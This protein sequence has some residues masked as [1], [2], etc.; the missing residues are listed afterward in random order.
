M[1]TSDIQRLLLKDRRLQ[2]I[3]SHRAAF[4]VGS[5]YPLE[6]F[7]KFVA[8]FDGYCA[9]EAS[10]KVELDKLIAGRFLIFFLEQFEEQLAKTLD[11]FRKVES[12]A[13][14]KISYNLLY[15]FLEKNFDFTK[16]KRLITG[17]DLRDNLADSSLKMHIVLEN[18]PEKV[19]TALA[20]DGNSSAVLRS[21]ALQ[22]VSL[23]GFD[24]YLDGRSEIEIYA[25]LT[26]EQF[27]EADTQAFLKQVFP[28]PVLQPLKATDTF[29]IGL[30][31]ANTQPVLYYH[32]KN[33]KEFLDYFVINDTAQKVHSFYQHQTHLDL[34]LGVTQ[35]ELQN[36][37]IENIRLYYSMMEIKEKK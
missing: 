8:D 37:R 32:L 26:E 29:I 34:W 23:I 13:D 12:R 1:M 35:Q 24:F 9:I 10:C 33:K 11:F 20:L 19:D 36:S 4:E 7:E 15:N 25:Q 21:I 2:F 6:I 30:S 27:Q 16:V 14:V 17:V 31:K 22:S 28:P 5:L 3:G 18:Y